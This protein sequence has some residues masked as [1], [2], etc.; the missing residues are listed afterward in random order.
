MT[1]GKPPRTNIDDL[2]QAEQ[3]LTPEE[4][5]EVHGGRNVQ[6]TSGTDFQFQS[7]ASHSFG[8]VNNDGRAEILTGAGPGAMPHVK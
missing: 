2:P 4:A 5:K 6:G 1:L 3:E 8:D 7:D